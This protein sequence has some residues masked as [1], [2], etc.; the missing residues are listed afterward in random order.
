M[1]YALMLSDELVK[2][3][4]TNIKTKG[5][6][7]ETDFSYTLNYYTTVFK[8]LLFQSRAL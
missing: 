3:T 7:N 4:N 6:L 8:G 5:N 2:Y 1:K